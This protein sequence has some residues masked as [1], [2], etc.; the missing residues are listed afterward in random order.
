MDWKHWLVSGLVIFT[1]GWMF[2]DGMRAFIVGDYATQATGD[3]ADHLYFGIVVLAIWYSSECDRFDFAI[4]H[5]GM[6]CLQCPSC[7]R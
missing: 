4:Y 2:F 7:A 1:A 5:E 3:Y 6:K